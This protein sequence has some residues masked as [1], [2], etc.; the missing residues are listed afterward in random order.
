[1]TEKIKNTAEK[2]KTKVQRVKEYVAEVG[3]PYCYQ[4][5]GITV[6]ISFAGKNKLEDCIKAVLLSDFTNVGAGNFGL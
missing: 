1:M 3:N 5:N 6:K 4:Y 2:E